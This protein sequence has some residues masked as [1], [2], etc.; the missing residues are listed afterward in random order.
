[1]AKR[2]AKDLPYNKEAEQAVLGSALINKEALYSVLSEL[3]QDDFFEGRHQIIYNAIYVLQGKGVDVDLLTIAEHLDN[4]KELE[5][6]GGSAYLQECCNAMVALASLS[7]YINIVRD[8]S[9]LRNLLI[10]TREINNEYLSGK[11]E[12]VDN[13]IAQAE[14]KIKLAT[15]KRRVST[16][17]PIEEVTKNVE[18]GL[19]TQQRMEEDYVTG[20]TTGY[21]SINK[22][23]QGFQKSEVTV[24]AARPSVGKTALALNFAYRVATRKKVPVAI[25]SLEMPGEQLVKRLVASASHVALQKISTGNLTEVEKAKVAAAIKEVSNAPIF[26]D[27]SSGIR[28]MDIV[29]K[30]RQLQAKHPDLGLI[31]IDYLGL[32]QTDIKSSNSRQDEVRR[33]S[34]TIHDL[35][36]DLKVPIILISQLNRKTEEENRRPMMSD[37]RESGSI[38]QDADVIM[39]LH[40]EDYRRNS[41]KEAAAGNKQLKDLSQSDRFEMVKKQ[42]GD[43]LPGDASYT[44]V[45]IAKNRN[46]P[47]GTAGLFFYKAFGRF[48][49]P[50]RE[51]EE[52][53]RNITNA[54]NNND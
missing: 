51:F 25:Y 20:L 54:I 47:T 38:E 40:R 53:M 4:I 33:I 15:E 41:K 45:I 29:A 28:L 3:K 9:V 7:F 6:V 18:M 39:L 37:L 5:N 32:V 34:L 50:S 43:N 36:K 48:D 35:A 27:D 44:E 13:F 16:F 26:I 42:L 10:A 46:G 8:Q 1:M 19:K 17:R 30:S 21:E 14:E 49:M 52:Q 22:L 23:T 24:I 12:D 31:I 11:I 2:V